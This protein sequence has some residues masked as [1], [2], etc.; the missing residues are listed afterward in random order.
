MQVL[1]VE[2]NPVNMMIL[3]ATL[4]KRGFDTIQAQNGKHALGILEQTGKTIDLIISDVMMPEMDG[5][6]MVE[7]IKEHPAWSTI[8]V[9][10]CTALNDKE[11]V[12]RAK[13]I[14]CKHYVV[15]P[16][17]TN[18]LLPKIQDA[19][20]E[21]SSHLLEKLSGR[22]TDYDERLSKEVAISF[23]RMVE[24]KIRFL[25]DQ[26]VDETEFQISKKF[27]DL[28]EAAEGF[29]TKWINKIINRLEEI[30]QETNGALDS[31][32]Y[33]RLLQELKKLHSIL[34]SVDLEDEKITPEEQ[35]D[36]FR[37]CIDKYNPQLLEKFNG[38]VEKL[39]YIQ[40]KRC[41]SNEVTAGMLAFDDVWAT[42]GKLLIA[43][44]Q[45]VNAKMIIRLRRFAKNSGVVEPFKMI[46]FDALL[47]QTSEKEVRAASSKTASSKTPKDPPIDLRTAMAVVDGDKSLYQELMEDFLMALPAQLD[48]INGQISNQDVKSIQHE[49]HDIKGVAGNLG[50]QIIVKHAVTLGNMAKKE[51]VSG[52][53]SI[54]Q[55]M[56]DE[57]ANVMVYFFGMDW[58]SD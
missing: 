21:D 27:A 13:Q 53:T 40:P 12:T 33:S 15:K 55:R 1:I 54:T 14:G 20:I 36:D 47:N 32:H 51:S 56:K 43:R 35:I 39:G 49:A 46:D 11:D 6:E 30:Q 19:L 25:E 18:V 22:A 37:K 38:M 2:D 10:M 41:D 8:P 45:E 42:V 29:G 34:P 57:I 9:I 44:G 48:K 7:K 24:E 52:A 28:K 16:V 23:S 3:K 31:D 5:F 50:L 58:E 4:Q 17:K 26:G